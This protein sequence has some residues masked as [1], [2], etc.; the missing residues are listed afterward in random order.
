MAMRLDRILEHTLQQSVDVQDRLRCITILVHFTEV[1]KIR[2]YAGAMSRDRAGCVLT[3]N[4]G[5]FVWKCRGMQQGNYKKLEIPH[6]HL[7]VQP[8]LRRLSDESN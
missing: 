4:F 1:P 5:S 6:T 8:S 7:K 2:L 3:R